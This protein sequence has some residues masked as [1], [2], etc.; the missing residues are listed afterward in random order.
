[1]RVCHKF[2]V[3]DKTTSW[4]AGAGEG[5]QA[6]RVCVRTLWTSAG[7]SCVVQG[8]TH[9]RHTRLRWQRILEVVRGMKERPTER[10]IIP[11]T[12]CPRVG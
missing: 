8:C 6:Q 9:R 1:M 3:H 7:T 10:A 12:K 5:L 2:Q 11:R 4:Y